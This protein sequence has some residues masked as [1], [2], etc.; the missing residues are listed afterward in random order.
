MFKLFSLLSHE[1][2]NNPLVYL[3]CR[4]LNTQHIKKLKAN[5]AELLYGTTPYESSD[6]VMEIGELGLYLWKKLMIEPMKDILLRLLLEAVHCHR[7]GQS[8]YN[9]K[10]STIHGIIQSFV[11]VDEFKRKKPLELYETVFE[12]P[13]LAATNEY[14]R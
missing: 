5:D 11:S 10:S 6:P 14:Y 9:E 4:Y 2:L 7:T 8:L 12:A 13:Y 1:T 3:Y